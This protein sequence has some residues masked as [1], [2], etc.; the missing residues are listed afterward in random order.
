MDINKYLFLSVIVAASAGFL[1]GFDTGNIAG[2]LVFISRD[3]HASAFQNESIVSITIFSAFLGAILSGTAVDYYGRKS[4]LIFAGFLYLAGTVF[5]TLSQSILE[6]IMA[7]FILGLAIGVSSY[8]APLYISE[9]APAQ[10]RGFFVL[11]NGVAITGGEAI[12]YALDYHFSFSQDWRNMFFVGI[13]PAVIFCIGTYFMPR[14]PRWLVTKGKITEAKK[15]LLKF[16]NPISAEKAFHEIQRPALHSEKF[17]ALIKNKSYKRL[18]LIG[19]ALGVFQQFFGI[20]VVMY[21]G[22]FIFQ[23]AGFQSASSDILLTFYLGV[24]K[25]Q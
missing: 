23:K 13:I 4:L 22:P 21:Y 16:H 9:I 5:S 19:I 17:I 24:V 15:I 18:L 11:L 3:F 25:F 7:R 10:F 14:S 20:N 8:T 2:A 1:F 6:L 12:A